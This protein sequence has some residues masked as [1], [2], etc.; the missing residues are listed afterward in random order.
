MSSN[1]ELLYCDSADIHRGSLLGEGTFGQV[2]RSEHSRLGLVA[3]KVVPTLPS[4]QEE[5]FREAAEHL[6]RLR[7]DNATRLYGLV[8]HP[9]KY[10][11]LMEYAQ[12]GPVE[13]LMKVKPPWPVRAKVMR[14]V[15][16]GLKY[17]HAHHVVH[18]NLSRH[19][20]VISSDL[21]AKVTDFG[22]REWRVLASNGYDGDMRPSAVTPLVDTDQYAPPET[23]TKSASEA[24]TCSFDIY[25]YGILSWEVITCEQA[26]K[27]WSPSELRSAVQKGHRPVLRAGRTEQFPAACPIT[28]R[29]ITTEAWR[30]HPA[31]RPAMSDL[32]RR[33]MT[34][35]DV[36]WSA[37][38]LRT[39]ENEARKKLTDALR[40][41]TRVRTPRHGPVSAGLSSREG[42]GLSPRGTPKTR[43]REQQISPQGTQL[44]PR[45]SQ[46]SPGVSR[47]SPHV[48][49]MPQRGSG[50]QTSRKQTPLTKQSGRKENS[51]GKSKPTGSHVDDQEKI[52]SSESHVGGSASVRENASSSGSGREVNSSHIGNNRCSARTQTRDEG[53][54][55]S[56]FT[57]DQMSHDGSQCESGAAG[58]QSADE[59]SEAAEE[60]SEAA[61]EPSEAAEEAAEALAGLA[62]VH[63]DFAERSAKLL[64]DPESG[65]NS[66]A[67]RLP[68]GFVQ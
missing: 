25:S 64:T 21:V 52:K 67:V 18:G 28:M 15:A 38:Q 8:L 46:V 34:K 11:L 27:G 58:G 16:T 49:R 51:N 1:E 22:L 40:V 55:E 31:D 6:Y 4:E 65:V 3:E 57:D 13:E 2:Y 9:D 59:P 14:E 60:P 17:L 26:W 61:E 32:L 35:S 48:S 42:S 47:V 29:N 20:V 63:L 5:R 23:F 30:Q 19:N 66:A 56:S 50:L 7:C 10:S 53:F 45:V 41:S 39:A 54:S 24:L 68:R 12:F 43:H 44:S 37:D 62:Q 33:M 36:Q